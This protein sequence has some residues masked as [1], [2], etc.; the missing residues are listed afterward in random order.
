[1]WGDS[2]FKINKK[3]KRLESKV[4]DVVDTMEKICNEQDR[5]RDIQSEESQF[6]IKAQEVNLKLN[7]LLGKL[8]N[9]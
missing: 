7:N 1:M 3:I 2:I 5:L 9:T 6:N 8:E 4:Y